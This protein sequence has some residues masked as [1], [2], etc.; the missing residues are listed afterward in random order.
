MRRLGMW[1]ISSK[2][3]LVEFLPSNWCVLED[4]ALVFPYGCAGLSNTVGWPA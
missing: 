1:R 3:W 2:D 4:R